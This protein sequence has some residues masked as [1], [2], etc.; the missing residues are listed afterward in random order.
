[1]DTG[2]FYGHAKYIAQ[3]ITIPETSDDSEL[4]YEGESDVEVVPTTSAV[5]DSI[6]D[7]KRP[8]Q[9]F[10]DQ[11]DN[12]MKNIVEQSNLYATQVNPNKPLGHDTATLETFIH[13]IFLMSIVMMPRAR[14]YWSL[15]L[16]FPK[17]ADVMPLARWETIKRM[18]HISDNLSCPANCTDH[19]YKSRPFVDAITRKVC[20]I[21]PGERLSIDEQII[22]FKGKSRLRQYNPKEPNIWG[23]KVFVLSGI[24]GLIHNLEVYTG[25]IDVCPGQP[26]L[27]VSANIVLRLLVNIPRALWH[28][29]FFDNWFNGVDLQATL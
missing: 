5:S 27:K 12:D 6:D 25:K 13:I 2:R 21:V 16:R 29:V 26:D 17:I 11:F 4:S 22:P 19:L 7:V 9:Y 23:Y 8:I 1:M 14:M 20:S 15:G 10:N 28:K 24:N 18:L 3:R